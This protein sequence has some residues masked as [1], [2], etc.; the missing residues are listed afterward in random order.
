MKSLIHFSAMLK[1]EKDNIPIK[2]KS[3]TELLL[4][5]HVH[6]REQYT[7]RGKLFVDF[8]SIRCEKI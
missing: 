7:A 3:E 4:L 8:Q 6:Q 1:Q 5:N 2:C